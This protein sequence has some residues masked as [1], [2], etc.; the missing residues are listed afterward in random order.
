[1][2]HSWQV[3]PPSSHPFSLEIIHVSS[4]YLVRTYWVEHLCLSEWKEEQ[5]QTSSHPIRHTTDE[6]V[7]L[8]R[9]LWPDIFF[10]TTNKQSIWHK[11]KKQGYLHQNLTHRFIVIV[12]GGLKQ[13]PGLLRVL[14]GTLERKMSS[15]P[16]NN[17]IK[18]K[19]AWVLVI[20]S[21][22]KASGEDWMSSHRVEYKRS[23][24][25]VITQGHSKKGEA[26]EEK[27]WW[28]EGGRER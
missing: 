15:W 4:I 18:K 9:S 21:P 14:L 3:Q 17:Q 8:G 16:L 10:S 23:G 20:Q 2:D 28:W 7:D 12:S 6:G 5:W 26:A 19:L 24:Q 1:M 25:S 27:H 13:R 11:G 22:S